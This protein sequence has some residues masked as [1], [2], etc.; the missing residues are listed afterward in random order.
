MDDFLLLFGLA[1][2]AN[3]VRLSR[4]LFAARDVCNI[5]KRLLV[6]T[7]ADLAHP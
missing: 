3:A 1:Q 2:R 5:G 7:I 4:A 6:R